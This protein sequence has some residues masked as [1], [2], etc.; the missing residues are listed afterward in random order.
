M[1]KCLGVL[2]RAYLD[3]N[4]NEALPEL[5]GLCGQSLAR[6]L[7]KQATSAGARKEAR[8]AEIHLCCVRSFLLLFSLRLISSS[9]IQISILIVVNHTTTCGSLTPKRCNPRISKDPNQFDIPFFHTVGQ[10]ARKQSSEG[11]PTQPTSA[12][13]RALPKF[14]HVS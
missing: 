6:V 2:K 7:P 13:Q 3:H 5:C 9:Q 11:L 8:E 12:R 4:A 1:Q 10:I 14:A